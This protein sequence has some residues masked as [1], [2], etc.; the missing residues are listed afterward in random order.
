MLLPGELCGWAAPL[1]MR[2]E[3]AVMV[4]RMGQGMVERNGFG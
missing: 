2:V 1:A 4:S 3:R